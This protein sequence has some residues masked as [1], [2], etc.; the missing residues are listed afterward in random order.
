MI[1][2]KIFL[3]VTI[4]LARTDTAFSLSCVL[5]SVM[6]WFHHNIAEH[7]IQ[8]CEPPSPLGQQEGYLITSAE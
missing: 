6:I 7:T 5:L 1:A 3:A 2:G 8:M 4:G